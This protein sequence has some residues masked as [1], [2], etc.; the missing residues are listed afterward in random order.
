MAVVSRIYEAA[1]TSH[2]KVKPSPV[3]TPCDH[4]SIYKILVAYI[5]NEA[6]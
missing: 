5:R 1:H 6:G 4:V 3:W 2:L